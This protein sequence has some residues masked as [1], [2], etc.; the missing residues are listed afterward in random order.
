MKQSVSIADHCDTGLPAETVM[1]LKPSWPKKDLM[2]K[3]QRKG[4][5]GK[6]WSSR[7]EKR[8][9]WMMKP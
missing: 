9:K 4:L 6:R 2:L 7:V 3:G 5:R 1:M 8:R